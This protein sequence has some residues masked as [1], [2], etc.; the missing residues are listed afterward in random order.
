[1]G[2]IIGG[3]S[4]VAGSL[5]GRG[6]RRAEAKS[7]AADFAAQRQALMDTEFTNVYAGLENVAED[8]TINQQASQFQ[9][10][11][12]DA[13]LAQAMQAAVASG[14]A[15]GG[16]QAIAAAALKSKQ[17]ISADIAR[18]EQANEMMR[19]KQAANLQTLE[20]QG[21]EDLQTA[22]Y[23]KQQDFLKLASARKQQADAAV[24]QSNKQLFGG[25]GQIVG[26]IAGG[27]LAPV[28]DAIKGLFGK[29]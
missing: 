7:A 18:Q 15:A 20:A 11:Q 22:N 19:V 26:G 23:E 25:L 14:G 1:M 6:A 8:L 24:A 27:G 9:A 13:A 3:V 4:N 29:K 12:T 17:G 16:A 2:S 28:G 10:Q 21:E 5:I